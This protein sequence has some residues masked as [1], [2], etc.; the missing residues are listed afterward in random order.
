M[1]KG[2]VYCVGSSYVVRMLVSI[3]SLRR[4]SP[5]IYDGPIAV[6]TMSKRSHAIG[7]RLQNSD[8]HVVCS[9]IRAVESGYNAALATKTM[10]FDETPFAATL[11]IDADTLIRGSLEELFSTP[12]PLAVTQFADWTTQH[13]HVR[14]HLEDWQGIA[15]DVDTLVTQCLIRTDPAI[16][17]GV[18][19][20]RRGYTGL[21]QWQQLAIRGASRPVADEIA[22]QL[23]LSQLPDCRV[24][25]DRWNF[26]PRDGKQRQDSRIWHFHS[27]LHRTEVEGAEL[28]WRLLGEVWENNIAGIQDWGP[29]VG[30]E[31]LCK[32][33]EQRGRI[34]RCT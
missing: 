23:L 14:K 34:R 5:P 25:D 16:N 32:F 22:I 3:W 1:E 6:F 30:D 13:E 31:D 29:S 8:L 15:D 9:Q 28:W 27:S 18:F 11:F 17:T 12:N 7:L 2:V 24:L 4:G 21:S 26:S 20:F 19:F 10:I 33:L